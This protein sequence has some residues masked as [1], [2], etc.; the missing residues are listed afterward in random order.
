MIFRKEKVK[1]FPLS[2]FC[3]YLISERGRCVPPGWYPLEE[4]IGGP[5]ALKYQNPP[6]IV[7]SC[8]TVCQSSM[9]WRLLADDLLSARYLT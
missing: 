7:Y 9:I 8:P 6:I 2:F 4:N 1:D 3:W 5:D